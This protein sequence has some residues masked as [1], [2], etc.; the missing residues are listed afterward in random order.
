MTI[1]FAPFDGDGR[2]KVE[3]I[4]PRPET[5]PMAVTNASARFLIESF[6]KTGNTFHSSQ[7]AVLWIVEA[8]CKRQNVPLKVEV[9]ILEGSIAGYVAQRQ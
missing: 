7:G 4:D 3:P 5:R 2:R 9:Q 6:C 1:D 8:W